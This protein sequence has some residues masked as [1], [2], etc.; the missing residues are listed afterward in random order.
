MYPTAH[1]AHP[2]LLFRP[3]IIFFKILAISAH[4]HIENGGIQWLLAMFFGHH[5]F[6][7][8][9][10]TTDG[11]TVAVFTAVGIAG[12]DTLEPG[13]FFRFLVIRRPH[14]VT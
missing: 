9:I 3:D 11:R 6:L 4:V 7:D 13:D 10:H 12:T 8:G 5:G 14:H 1:K 2:M